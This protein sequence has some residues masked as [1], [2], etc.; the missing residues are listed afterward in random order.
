MKFKINET[1][2][3][4]EKTCLIIAT[5]NEPY[6]PKI[7]PFNRKEIFP[8]KDYLIIFKKDNTVNEY[9]G[10][11]DVYESQIEFQITF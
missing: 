8:S 3:Y 11:S 7:D 1:V 6:N 10:I 2:I 4:T 9:A 5:K